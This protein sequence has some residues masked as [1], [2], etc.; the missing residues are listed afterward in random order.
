[1]FLKA[2]QWIYSPSDLITYLESPFL[3]W[4]TRYDK[5]YPG[6]LQRDDD[7][8]VLALFARKGLEHESRYL[9][10]LKSDGLSVIEIDNN[11]DAFNNTAQAIQSDADVIFQ[12]ALRSGNFRG[13]AD[14]LLKTKSENSKARF[15]PAD[16]KLARKPK[17]YFIIQLCCYSEML[18]EI[19][20]ELPKNIHVI[21]GDESVKSYR[22]LDY[23]FYYLQI[24]KSF[25]AFMNSFDPEQPPELIGN[26]N[27]GEWQGHVDQW[28]KDQDH[29]IRV[30]NIRVSQI[31]R[32]KKHGIVTMTNLAETQRDTVPGIDQDTFLKLKKQ[33][34]LQIKAEKEG[35]PSFE[36]IQQSDDDNMIRGLQLLPPSS[37]ND[38]Y[39][40][41][42]GYPFVDSGLEYLFGAVCCEG[43]ETKFYDYWAHNRAEEKI[44][45]EN[46]IDWVYNK[47]R[48]DTNLHIY[49]YANY[50]V[51]ALRRLSQLHATREEVVDHLLRSCVFID[52]YQIVKNSMVVGEPRYSI[53]NLEHF[54]MPSR[55]DAVKT[56]VDSIIYYEKWL[57]ENDGQD[58]HT[59]KLLNDIRDYNKVDCESMI[60]LANWLRN[61]QHENNIKYRLPT[62]NKKVLEE[63]PQ[64]SPEEIESNKMLEEIPESI[65]GNEESERVWRLMAH[66][67]VYHKR[68]DKPDWWEYF[69]RH[70]KTDDE[71]AEDLECLSGL[72]QVSENIYEYSPDQDTKLKDGSTCHIAGWSDSSATITITNIDTDTGRV[73]LRSP[74]ASLADLTNLSLIPYSFINKAPLTKSIQD[75]VSQ[76][77]TNHHMRP[78]LRSFLFREKPRLTIN[79]EDALISDDKNI[80]DELI[81]LV[82]IMDETALC[83][84]GPPGTGKTFICASV[85]LSLLKKGKKVGI[86]SN[87]H[88][89]ITNLMRYVAELAEKD[90]FNFHGMKVG[91]KGAEDVS[92]FSCF[93]I[94]E[95]KDFDTKASR[96]LLVGGTAWLFSR[97]S[98]IDHFDYLFVDEAGQVSLANLVAVSRS[99]KNIVLIGDQMQLSQPTKGVHPDESGLSC[100]EYYLQDHQTIPPDQGV[101]LSQTW[102]LH[103]DICEVI[104]DIVYEGRL[105]A[106][107]E[108]IQRSI[109]LPDG[110]KIVKRNT[111][112]IFV[113]VDHTDNAQGSDEEVDAISNIIKELTQGTFVDKNGS[114]RKISLSDDILIVAP[115][116]LQIIKL[117]KALGAT[118]RIGTVDKFQGQEAPIVIVSMA[119]SSG[120]LSTRGA[121]FLFNKNRINVAITRAQCLA[122]IVG[123]P[124]LKNTHCTNIA[125]M[126]RVNMFCRVTSEA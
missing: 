31:K 10:K 49:H 78:A 19:F 110:C 60:P 120:N 66:F 99:C 81:A 67:L 126:E 4:L 108:N 122:I 79:K 112:I 7:N 101:F 111:G 105:H 73:E 109:L 90:G 115:Y 12:A 119:A 29:L 5:E 96:Y 113:P 20:G 22:T 92:A 121:E 83:V 76:Y 117:E 25:L 59:S 46:F 65:R 39:F 116:N 17:P 14:F 6:K 26:E 106:H 74:K 123:S 43:D 100:L 48:E 44:A 38:I 33:A 11:D 41:M 84:Q 57:E 42:E 71:L 93:D 28:L 58:W 125:D 45:F 34:T 24:K 68:A 82:G 62:S 2:K 102:R 75:T 23:Y 70:E 72:R 36:I 114:K 61:L 54:Y 52:L 16:T 32:L 85:I 51:A 56:A 50:E 124:Q 15:E 30:A 18:S 86:T 89:A 98:A 97:P 64:L 95:S 37:K 77:A 88:H 104:S 94:G 118:A 80:I 3:S 47:Y 69:D 107:P 63:E 1:M 9:Q 35:N 40:D 87:G 91:K 103:P 27:F 55:G 13:F 53:K 8:E 21:L